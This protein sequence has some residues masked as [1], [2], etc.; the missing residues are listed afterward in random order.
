MSKYLR[1]RPFMVVHYSYVLT[2]GQK[3]SVPGFGADAEWDPVENMVIVDRVSDKHFMKA[4]LILDLFE[5]KVLKCRDITDEG[6]RQKLFDRFV[7]RHFEEV[8]GALSTWIAR[9][10]NNLA[11]VQQ[12]VEKHKAAPETDNVDEA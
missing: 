8:K 3:S 10:P 5:G 6:D 4:D 2:A 11:K 7:A 12:F 9:D 1:N